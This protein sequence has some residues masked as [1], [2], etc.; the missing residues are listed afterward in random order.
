MLHSLSKQCCAWAI[1]AQHPLFHSPLTIK[2]RFPGEVSSTVRASCTQHQLHFYRVHLASLARCHNGKFPYG[3]N[4]AGVG[5]DVL[6]E[7][8]GAR[9][10]DGPH[11]YVRDWVAEGSTSASGEASWP[12]NSL[13]HALELELS[14][15]EADMRLVRGLSLSRA[16][17]Y[18]ALP[19]S[20]L[21][22]CSQ[23]CVLQLRLPIR[24]LHGVQIMLSA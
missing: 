9:H 12:V 16:N 7:H 2:A 22:R 24:W 18:A 15:Q 4:A 14:I 20:N 3:D 6:G 21:A 19:V 10:Q 13:E 17:H 1:T 11:S 8:E 23:A 5:A